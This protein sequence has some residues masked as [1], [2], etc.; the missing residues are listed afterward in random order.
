MRKWFLKN[1]D[2]GTKSSVIRDV[3]RGKEVKR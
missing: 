3:K 2:S 1:N